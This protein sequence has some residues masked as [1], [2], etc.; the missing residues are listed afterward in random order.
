VLE[1]DLSYSVNVVHCY[2]VTLMYTLNKLCIC[3]NLI[4]FCYV[5]NKEQWSLFEC[6]IGQYTDRL[7]DSPNKNK[8]K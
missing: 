6:L 1:S 8:V 4:K 2:S 3:W 7:L 5:K